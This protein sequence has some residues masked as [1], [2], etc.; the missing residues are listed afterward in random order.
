MGKIKDLTGQRFGRLTVL[1]FKG[2]NK[3]HKSCWLC[4][5]DCGNEKII[6]GE[7]LTRGLTKSCGCLDVEK[8][9]T[10]PNRKAHGMTGTRLYRIWKNIKRRCY[11]QNNEDYKRWYGSKGVTMCDEWKNNFQSFYDWSIN[12]GYSDDLTIDRIDSNCNYEPNNCRWVDVKTQAQN[13]SQVRNITINGETH[14]LKEWCRIVKIAPTTVYKRLRDGW[15][16]RSAILTQPKKSK[17]KK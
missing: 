4:K 1:E 13:T 2:V 9:V 3:H 8:H 10:H 16:E 6:V 17:R 14:C 15:D 11:N 5:C 7:S 12:H